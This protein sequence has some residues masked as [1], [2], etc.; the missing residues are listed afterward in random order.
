[1]KTLGLTFALSIPAIS[2]AHNNKHEQFNL[3]PFEDNRLQGHASLRI[4]EVKDNYI[5]AFTGP[6]YNFT[7]VDKFEEKNSEKM[8]IIKNISDKIM[9][10]AHIFSTKDFSCK[11]L[12]K[13]Y[14]RLS[15]NLR[16]KDS[17]MASKIVPMSEKFKYVDRYQ[18]IT[19]QYKLSCKKPIK[20]DEMNIRI[21]KLSPHLEK[22][23]IQLDTK[24]DGKK[25]IILTRSEMENT[26]K[27]KEKKSS[28][29]ASNKPRTDD[30]KN[31]KPVKDHSSKKSKYRSK[32]P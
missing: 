12:I 26:K 22:L 20:Y 17:K 27:I 10:P 31:Q 2:L 25:S 30:K 11:M 24:I 15:Y 3:P 13:P 5:I 18:N 29:V 32:K 1:M 21:F 23:A 6:T 19:S 9:N 7:K 16:V 4:T 28:S 8:L 14:V